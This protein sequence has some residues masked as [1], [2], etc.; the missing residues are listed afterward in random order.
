MDGWGYGGMGTGGWL[1]MMLLWVGL[2]VLVVWL[3]AGL[4]PRRGEP[5]TQPERPEETLDRRLVR[6]EIDIETY[7]QLRATLGERPTGE[8]R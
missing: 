2:I 3:V 7:K 4:F 6:G 1:L 5:G 8:R